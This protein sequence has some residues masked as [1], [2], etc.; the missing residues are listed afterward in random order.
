MTEMDQVSYMNT[1]L[2]RTSR[3]L[4]LHPRTVHLG[5]QEVPG[6][7]PLELR[8]CLICGS[9]VSKSIEEVIAEQTHD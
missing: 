5:M 4:C 3:A 9:T 8:N 1:V 2:L 6:E 7:K